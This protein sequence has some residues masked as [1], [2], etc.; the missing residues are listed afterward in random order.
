VQTKLGK[1]NT[2]SNRNDANDIGF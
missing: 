2:C 1:E